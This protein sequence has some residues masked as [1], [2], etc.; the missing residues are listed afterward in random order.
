MTR[1]RIFAALAVFVLASCGGGGGGVD[2][3]DPCLDFGICDDYDY[4]DEEMRITP[5]SGG[6]ASPSPESL[7]ITCDHS[8]SNPRY[9]RDDWCYELRPR[10]ETPGYIPLIRENNLSYSTILQQI[11]DGPF[12]RGQGYLKN[13][14]IGR[15][16]GPFRGI[17]CTSISE[18]P[19]TGPLLTDA[20]SIPIQQIHYLETPV[21]ESSSAAD[22]FRSYCT[23]SSRDAVL[24]GLRERPVDP[25]APTPTT[26]LVRPSYCQP[27]G[28]TGTGTGTDTGA[29]CSSVESALRGWRGHPGDHARFH[30]AAA[31]IP[32][33]NRAA[34]CQI[35]RQ[36]PPAPGYSPGT[37]ARQC[38]YCGG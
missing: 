34:N 12:G 38:S 25:C 31:C 28:G 37:A 35:L 17:S 16:C 11:N 18:I 21:A 4:G 7:W 26:Q 22:E 3:P 27:G 23:G 36:W 24:E 5:G 15:L 29:S 6:S 13:C 20:R 30:C 10:P 8:A 32:G 9:E 1:V 14:R 2:L 33:Q 19:E